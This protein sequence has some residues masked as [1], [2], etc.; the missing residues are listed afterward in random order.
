MRILLAHPNPEQRAALEKEL[1]LLGHDVEGTV[2][3]GLDVLCHLLYF[4]S[5]AMAV[6]LQQHMPRCD[7]FDTLA[8][9]RG[10]AKFR[11]VRAIIVSDEPVDASI[12]SHTEALGGMFATSDALSAAV[13]QVA[14][15][16]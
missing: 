10:Y 12:I 2:E 11:D 6:V 13:S 9:L 16:M 1:V 8:R 15:T 3:D 5:Q 4:G 7:G 14:L